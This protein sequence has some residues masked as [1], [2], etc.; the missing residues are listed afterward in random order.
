[1]RTLHD[2]LVAKIDANAGPDACWWWCGAWSKKGWRGHYRRPSFKYRGR[3]V[4]PFRLLLAL[5]RRQPLAAFAGLDAAHTC[6][7]PECVNPTHGVWLP[8]QE[9]RWS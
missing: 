4:N 1:M 7:N 2:R 5:Y 3:A 6:N 9:N 8:P